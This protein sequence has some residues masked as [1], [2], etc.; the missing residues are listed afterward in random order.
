MSRKTAT[1][2][3]LLLLVL[4]PAC[5]KSGVNLDKPE[6]QIVGLWKSGERTLSFKVGGRMVLTSA[7][8]VEITRDGSK[9]KRTD[10]N[11][12]EGTYELEPADTLKL[13]FETEPQLFAIMSGE[14]RH[15][16]TG[17]DTLTLTPLNELAS[18]PF[19]APTVWKRAD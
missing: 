14:Y 11:T 6:K 17:S 12:Y 10:T 5:T 4:V 16:F 13:T 2:A 3:V 19:A 18:L 8:E 15:A 1:F 9:E 7:E